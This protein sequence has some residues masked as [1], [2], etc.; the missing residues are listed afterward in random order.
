MQHKNDSQKVGRIMSETVNYVRF[1]GGTTE[2]KMCGSYN[3]ILTEDGNPYLISYGSC[4]HQPFNQPTIKILFIQI[5]IKVI[6]TV[7]M[8]KLKS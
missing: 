1:K 4:F 8:I 3:Y 2:L 5:H 6:D 7:N